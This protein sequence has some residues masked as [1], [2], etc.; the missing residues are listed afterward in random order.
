MICQP[1]LTALA[2]TTNPIAH[3]KA[4]VCITLGV[5]GFKV[6]PPATPAPRCR[7]IGI[8]TFKTK[9]QFGYLENVRDINTRSPAGSARR[10]DRSDIIVCSR[11]R[12]E[13]NVFSQEWKSPGKVEARESCARIVSREFLIS[14]G[15]ID[16][17]EA[18]EKSVQSYGG[19]PLSAKD[20][21][22]LKTNLKVAGGRKGKHLR[23]SPGAIGCSL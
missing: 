16:I 7:I 3:H 20:N 23:M 15:V 22:P 18:L 1:C 17:K 8:N 12:I 6:V 21:R 11:I 5:N 14:C 19:M 9:I 10:A 4:F 13:S 2:L